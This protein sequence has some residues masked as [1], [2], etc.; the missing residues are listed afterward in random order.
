MTGFSARFQ[1]AG[2]KVNSLATTPP[3][4]KA[5]TCRF[6]IPRDAQRGMRVP[7]H[8]FAGEDFLEEI[9]GTKALEQAINVAHLPGIVM[10]SIAMPDIHEGYGFPIGGV[11]ACDLDDGVISPGGVGYDINCGVRLCRSDLTLDEVKPRIRDITDAIFK[12]VPSGVGKEGKISLSRDETDELLIKGARW[13]LD[14]GYGWPEDIE[15]CEEGGAMDGANPSRVSR[16]A[17]ERGKGQVGTLGSGNHFIEVGYVEEVYDENTAKAF[18]LFKDQIVFWVHSGSRGFGHQVCQDN[19]D[20]MRKTTEKYG[21]KLPDRQLD[22]APFKSPEGQAYFG[23]MAAAA[24]YAWANRQVLLHLVREAVSREFGRG[25]ETLGM[26]LVYDVAHNIAKIEEHEVEGKKKKLIVHRK[27]A[28]RAFPSGHPALPAIYR[29]S[30][31][32]VLV[33]GDMGRASYVL[34]GTP[35]AMRDSFGSACHGAGR[36]LSRQQAKRTMS[37][38]ELLNELS[39]RGVYVRSSTVKSLIEEAPQAYK[40]VDDVVEATVAAGLARK[41]V[42]TRPLGVVKG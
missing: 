5:G 38:E 19:L 21:I 33:P 13:A 27:G 9:K 15:R 10:A 28:T 8:I 12:T 39:S 32:P 20:I 2:K 37:A 11:A 25:A 6:V 4:Q 26:K 34:V 41:V 35:E 3:I 17:Y 18:G 22:C 29:E 31:Q 24:N 16:K 14:K 1:N 23:A 7:C 42:K 36:A 30:G 40:D